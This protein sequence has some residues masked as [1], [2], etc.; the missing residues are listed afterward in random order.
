M[1]ARLVPIKDTHVGYCEAFAAQLRERGFRVEVDARNESMGLKTREA[2][3]AK[4][5][6]SFVAGD[7]EVTAQTFSARKYGERQSTVQSQADLVTM[8][9]GLIPVV[10][11][12]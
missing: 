10:A 1:Q 3:M 7:Q 4:I 11:G 2:Q 12:K 9:S 6:Y 8:L 5:P